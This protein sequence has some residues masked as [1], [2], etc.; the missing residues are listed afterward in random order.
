MEIH[1]CA[2]EL[3]K[4]VK[5]ATNSDDAFKDVDVCIFLGGFPRKPGMTRADL[6]KINTKIFMG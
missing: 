1:D 2:Y 4:G 6:L 3:L 5:I